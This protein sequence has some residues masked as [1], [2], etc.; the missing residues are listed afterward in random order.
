[1]AQERWPREPGARAPQRRG[2]LWLLQA[3]T[4][5]LLLALLGV[6]IIANHFVVEG[7]LR[8]YQDVVAYLSHPLIFVWEILFLVVVSTHAALGLRAIVL[9]LGPGPRVE[10]LV[11][12]VLVLLTVFA[13][14][15][16]ICLSLLIRRMG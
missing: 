4:G 2:S 5:L 10:R 12:G 8:T 13:I 15:Y 1:M 7:G 3:V 9:D 6:H 14:G 11:N 16:G